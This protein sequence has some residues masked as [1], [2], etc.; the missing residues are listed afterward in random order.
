[1]MAVTPPTFRDFL[2][3]ASDATAQVVTV[4]DVFGYYVQIYVFPSI[5]VIKVGVMGMRVA[6]MEGHRDWEIVG[7]TTR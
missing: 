7:L 6:L 4:K 2:G 3:W 5:M 1:M